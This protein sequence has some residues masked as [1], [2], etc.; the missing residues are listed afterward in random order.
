MVG[1]RNHLL[2]LGSAA[3]P[4]VGELRDL[5]ITLGLECMDVSPL[6]ECGVA[7]AHACGELG[8]ADP[9]SC[10]PARVTVAQGVCGDPVKTGRL[11]QP[12]KRGADDAVA[13]E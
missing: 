1:Q 3:G 9:R 7:M 2:T 6:G 12:G 11:L 8:R 5:R 10:G 4:V 13:C